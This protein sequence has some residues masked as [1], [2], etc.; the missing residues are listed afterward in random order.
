MRN[1]RI[2]GTFIAATFLAACGGENIEQGGNESVSS[3]VDSVATVD[4]DGASVKDANFL[5]DICII[6]SGNIKFCT[7]DGALSALGASVQPVVYLYFNEDSSGA[8]VAINKLKA[9]IT[10]TP[11][12]GESS[13]TEDDRWPAGSFYPEVVAD[14]AAPTSYQMGDNGLITVRAEVDENCSFTSEYVMVGQRLYHGASEND[15]DCGQIREQSNRLLNQT[16]ERDGITIPNFGSKKFLEERYI[17]I[18]GRTADDSFVNEANNRKLK[19]TSIS[20]GSKVLCNWQGRGTFYPGTI[21]SR[22]GDSIDVQYDDGDFERTTI[23]CIK[24]I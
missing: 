12:T 23:K 1:I 21:T 14:K 3:E 22:D 8:F 11:M 15:G 2:H 18:S 13:G 6:K 17:K 19:S 24:D 5:K 20:V 7:K 10:A 4:E 16:R 9:G